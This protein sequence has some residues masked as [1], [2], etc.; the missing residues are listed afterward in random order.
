MVRREEDSSL[1][2]NWR[3]GAEAQGSRNGNRVVGLPGEIAFMSTVSTISRVAHCSSP[4]QDFVVEK[5]VSDDE[6][7][8]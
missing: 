1:R 5:T 6:I 3:S 2:V 4:E 7:D 8:P